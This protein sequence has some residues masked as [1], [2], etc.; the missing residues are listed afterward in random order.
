MDHKEVAR[1]MS[2]PLHAFHRTTRRTI[3]L[4]RYER[5]LYQKLVVKHDKSKRLWE[6]IKA[7]LSS[8]ERPN[9]AE[10]LSVVRRP[11]G[12]TEPASCSSTVCRDDRGRAGLALV[13]AVLREAGVRTRVHIRAGAR[14]WRCRR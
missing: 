4:K 13:L 9:R 7:R 1:I 14:F 11:T 3:R 5:T 10:R 12:G 6:D 2:M 8:E